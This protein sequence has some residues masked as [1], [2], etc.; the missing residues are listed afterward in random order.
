MPS[1]GGSSPPRDRTRA[2]C[3]DRTGLYG[4]SR[5]NGLIETPRSF[6]PAITTLLLGQRCVPD[7]QCRWEAPC[8]GSKAPWTPAGLDRACRER[9][10]P[11][12]TKTSKLRQDHPHFQ[13]PPLARSPSSLKSPGWGQT[14][15]SSTRRDRRAQA[16]G[17]AQGLLSQKAE[18]GLVS[19]GRKVSVQPLSRVRLFA[20]P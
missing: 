5:V 6:R 16:F 20:T 19:V 7:N 14:A 9:Y 3:I 8:K 17:A 12:V 1:S 10:R 15:P 4:L 11:L 18:G 13:P 2:S